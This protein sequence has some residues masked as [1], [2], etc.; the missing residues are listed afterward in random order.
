MDGIPF[1]DVPQEI[2]EEIGRAASHFSIGFVRMTKRKSG[3]NAVL[4]GSG[5]LV[6]VDGLYGVLTAD[7]V[8]EKLPAT[9]DIGLIIP[10][11]DE[12]IVHRPTLAR[13]AVHRLRI[14]HGR[15]TR[16]GPDLGLLL[17]SSVD[18]GWLEARK[19]FYNLTRHR[20]EVLPNP[21]G[22]T[23]G[24]WVLCG[25]ADEFTIEHEPQRGFSKIK[26]FHGACGAGWVRREY[27]SGD[28][29]YC[30][31]EVGDAGPDKPPQSFGGFSGGGLWQARLARMP[32][33]HLIAHQPVLGG[34]AFYESPERNG[35]NVIT[36][37]AWRSIYARVVELARSRAS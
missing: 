5:T 17:L 25:F 10:T 13:D 20:D 19:S 34:V 9:Q 3:E 35:R 24:L 31:F 21:P 15:C 37:H 6:Q 29:D 18:A 4:G 2:V 11:R 1:S 12:P 7:H 27:I 22:R 36:C 16:E 33:G 32:E 14:G 26:G 23:D 28:F 30:E 8:L